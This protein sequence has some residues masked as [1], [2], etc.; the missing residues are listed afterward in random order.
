[1]TLHTFVALSVI[2]TLFTTESSSAQGPYWEASSGLY[3]GSISWIVTAR[4]GTVFTAGS[5]PDV[6]RSTDQGLSW[7]HVPLALTSSSR[8]A[9]DSGGRTFLFSNGTL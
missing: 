8:A 5:T 6:F 1:M 9:T 2:A 7:S 4:N 3:G